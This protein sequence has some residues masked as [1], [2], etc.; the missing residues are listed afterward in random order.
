[1]RLSCLGPGLP[2]AAEDSTEAGRRGGGITAPLTPLLWLSWSNVSLL[3]KTN[4]ETK[5]GAKFLRGFDMLLVQRLGSKS[6]GSYTRWLAFPHADVTAQAFD[7]GQQSGAN[8]AIS[9]PVPGNN[10]GLAH[11]VKSFNNEPMG[12]E[13]SKKQTQYTISQKYQ[14]KSLESYASAED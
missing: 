2:S 5:S 3:K 1:M 7:S 4:A 11:N 10:S 14:V 12:Y 6:I 9:D 8:D 13:Q